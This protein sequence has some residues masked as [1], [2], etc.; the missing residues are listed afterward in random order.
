[1]ELEQLIGEMDVILNAPEDF[2]K[3]ELIGQIDD[4]RKRLAS[5]SPNSG[6]PA[7]KAPAQ[8]CHDCDDTGIIV[9]ESGAFLACDCPAGKLR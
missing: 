3:R 9:G 5:T 7:G 4:W 6:L 1:M 2:D 8:I